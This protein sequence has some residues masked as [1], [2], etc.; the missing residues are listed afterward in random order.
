MTTSTHDKTGTIGL[1]TG[2]GSGLGEAAAMRLA[3][4][5]ASIV[6]ADRDAAAARRVVAA[7]TQAGGT[8]AAFTVDVRS[9]DETQALVQFA[10]DSYGTLDFALNNAG[11]TPALVEVHEIA[12]QAWHDVIDINLTGVF[13]SMKAE[14]NHMLAAGGGAILNMSSTA[15]VMAHAGRAAYAASKHGI[16]G[17]T[18]SAAVEYAKRGVRINAVAPGPI[19]APSARALSP[20]EVVPAW[21]GVHLAG[22]FQHP[23]A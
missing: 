15:G 23:A 8:A 1:V 9:Y 16:V 17:L 6:V 13:N 22:G 3:A 20:G 2:A 19:D 7:I 12:L 5:G 18:R 10:V 11:I 4:D 14:L 21:P